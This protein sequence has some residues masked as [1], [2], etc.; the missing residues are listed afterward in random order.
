MN[1]FTIYNEI[2]RKMLIIDPMKKLVALQH[3]EI[4]YEYLSRINA[5]NKWS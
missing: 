1:Q 2:T 5:A 4:K 3:I